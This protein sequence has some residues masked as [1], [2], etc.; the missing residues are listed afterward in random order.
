MGLK[1]SAAKATAAMV[2]PIVTALRRRAEDLAPPTTRRA[3]LQQIN[4]DALEIGPFNAP[5]LAGEN[6]SYFD[7]LDQEALRRRAIEHGRDPSRTPLID[8]VSP[9]GDLASVGRKFDSVLSAHAIEHQPDLIAHLNAVA[10]VLNPGGAYYVIAPDKRYCFD[11]YL[12]ESTIEDVFA[13]RGRLRH[14]LKSVINHRLHVTINRAIRHWLG[15]HG[16]APAPSLEQIAQVEAEYEIA[17]REGSYLDVHAWMF[18]PSGFRAIAGGLGASLVVE[19][20]HDTGFG[21]QEFFA[22]LRKRL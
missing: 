14:T 1:S 8:F 5:L 18:T 17:E 19:R 3:F 13:A 2:K 11:H 4:G 20:I 21:E 16:P 7:L 6:V 15:Q 10:G 22:I 9:T 12:P